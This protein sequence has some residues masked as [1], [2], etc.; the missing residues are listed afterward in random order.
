MN[1]FLKSK[2]NSNSLSFVLSCILSALFFI[3]IMVL[4]DE[5]INIP[6]E[7]FSN[8][9]KGILALIILLN[10]HKFIKFKHNILVVGLTA[11]H[12]LGFILFEQ[13]NIILRSDIVY[14][15]STN[16][17]IILITL[18]IDDYKILYEYL[19]RT[20]YY[21]SFTLL[22]ICFYIIL[23]GKAF[24]V[25]T[26]K[27]FMGV[28]HALIIH[29]LFLVVEF[30]KTKKKV[31]FF[32]VIFNLIII[33]LIGSRSVFIAFFLLLGILFFKK[34]FL[35]FIAL[36]KVNLLNSLF[37]LILL[38]VLLPIFSFYFLQNAKVFLEKYEIRSRSISLFT[39][40][41]GLLHTSSRTDIYRELLRKIAETPFKIRGFMAD[42][43]LDNLQAHNFI[44]EM[45]Y[46][47]GFVLGIIPILLWFYA[48]WKNLKVMKGH[49]YEADLACIFFCVA[50]PAYMLH[51][52]PILSI[53][54]SMWIAFV[55]RKDFITISKLITK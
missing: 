52:N 7:I 14:F 13:E 26:G 12:F 31:P 48:C 54:G 39:T 49:E 45:L 32:L 55:L 9:T 46:D 25:L 15:L 23:S 22:I 24:D 28:S 34:Y 27:Y 20:S 41:E 16:L 42:Q 18:S 36:K 53:N 4:L 10:L 30:F 11:L 17:P 19:L 35:S 51:G 47:F 1:F 37:M 2:N 8:I 40:K 38:L 44:I 3:N 43:Y 50:F 33:L 21:I 5:L 29:T 6:Q